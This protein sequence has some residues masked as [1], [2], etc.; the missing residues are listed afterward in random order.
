MGPVHPIF[1]HLPIGLLIGNMILTLWYLRSAGPDRRDVEIAAFYCL[2]LGLLL[3]LPA[4]AAGTWDALAHVS[5]GLGAA[6]NIMW[7]NAHALAGVLMCVAY[8]QAWNIRR[9]NPAV[10]DQ[11]FA[12]RGYLARLALGAVLLLVG[13]WIGGHMVYTLRIGPVA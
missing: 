6:S 5:R 2:K 11:P 9:R 1:V 12:R 3:V 8:W 10:L 4:I 7:I 13:G